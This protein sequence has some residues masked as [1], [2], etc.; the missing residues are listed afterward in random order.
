[1]RNLH[2]R[3]GYPAMAIKEGKEALADEWLID[4]I[5]VAPLFRD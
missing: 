1:M 4:T 3:Y 2:Y 5:V